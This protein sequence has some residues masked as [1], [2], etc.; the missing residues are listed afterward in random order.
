MDPRVTVMRRPSF[1][2]SSP[3]GAGYQRVDVPAGEQPFSGVG[4]VI[5]DDSIAQHFADVFGLHVVV[6]AVL[7]RL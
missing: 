1:V 4:R 7:Q 2:A 6:P 5:Q 3:N